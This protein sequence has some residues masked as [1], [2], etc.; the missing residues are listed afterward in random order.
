MKPYAAYTALVAALREIRRERGWTGEQ[1]SL[2]MGRNA[3]YISVLEYR[4]S[5]NSRHRDGRH[6]YDGPSLRVLLELAAGHDVSME[7]LGRRIDAR[8]SK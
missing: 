3:T 2:R 6:R 1:V 4:R 5:K 8:I 7:E